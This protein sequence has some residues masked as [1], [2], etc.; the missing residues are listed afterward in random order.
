LNRAGKRPTWLREE[1]VVATAEYT[2]YAKKRTL[3]AYFALLSLEIVGACA[4]FQGLPFTAKSRWAQCGEAATGPERG[5]LSRS[6]N[7]AVA[8]S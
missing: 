1:R 5:C 6:G 7:K 2:K 8:A 3:S 4:D